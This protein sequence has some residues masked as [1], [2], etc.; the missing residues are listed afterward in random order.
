MKLLRQLGS[1][2]GAR[3]LEALIQAVL[4][5]LLARELGPTLFGIVAIYHAVHSVIFIV[6]G[7]NTATFVV[8]EEALGRPDLAHGALRMNSI[9]LTCALG[10]LL[11]GSL[12]VADKP[13]ICLA[14]AANAFGAWSQQLGDNRLSLALAHHK[15]RP[16]VTAVSARSIS[17]L[18]VFLGL[19]SLHANAALAFGVAR[20]GAGLV[21]LG[22]VFLL[23]PRAGKIEKASARRVT[24]EQFPLAVAPGVAALRQFDTVI[25]TLISGL[26]ASGLYSAVSRIASP[27]VLFSAAI[28]PVVIPRVAKAPQDKVVKLFDLLFVG[29]ILL[30]LLPLA[31]IPCAE[32]MVVSIFGL[33]FSGG[34]V[35]M[36]WML[37]RV[38]EVTIGPVLAGIL[39]A[40]RLDRTVAVNAVLFT[41][42]ML[43]GTLVGALHS[44]AAGAAAGVAIVGLL[45]RTRLWLVGRR[46]LRNS[47]G[48]TKG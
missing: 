10:L 4:L 6:V 46:L 3:G 19:L 14:V 9:L 18:L 13:L 5:I 24:R 33:E 27:L 43:I 23:V 48:Q 21:G 40:R 36:I 44:G 12:Y 11:A 17:S 41:A 47:E 45:G 34:G 38:G 25:V 39:Q 16:S 15:V 31:L 30:T 35:V 2:G 28:N 22:L 8:R 26:A 37:L 32:W 7:M 29:L 20:V 42:F 1:M